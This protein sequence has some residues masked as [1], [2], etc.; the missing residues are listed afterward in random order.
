MCFALYTVSMR[1]NTTIPETNGIRTGLYHP[2]WEEDAGGVCNFVYTTVSADLH[3]PAP[4]KM[5][6]MPINSFLF[7]FKK[8]KCF[9]GLNNDCVL[10]NRAFLEIVFTWT[11]EWKYI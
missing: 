11:A 10:Y 9:Y 2:L 5:N 8:M 4:S 6:D 3:K 1:G 7:I